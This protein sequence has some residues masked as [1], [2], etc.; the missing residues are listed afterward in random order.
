MTCGSLAHAVAFGYDSPAM[1]PADTTR[2]SYPLERRTFMALVSGGLLATPLA[3]EAQQAKTVPRLGMLFIG[4]PSV[5]PGPG[6]DAFM[7]QLGELGWVEGR[8]LAVERR[9]ADRPDRLPDVAAE[10]IRLNVSVI[11]APGLQAAQA[12]KKST[13]T[14]PIVMVAFADPASVPSGKSC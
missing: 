9:W 13:L 8:N 4:S 5:P 11:L 2:G 3:A 6:E 12:A 14:I 10:L 7:K 1:E